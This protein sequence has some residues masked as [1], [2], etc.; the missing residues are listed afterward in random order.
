M[1]NQ[2]FSIEQF[3]RRDLILVH[4]IVVASKIFVYRHSVQSSKKKSV[5]VK[6]V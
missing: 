4:F 3:F 1:R 5:S 2:Y 6:F